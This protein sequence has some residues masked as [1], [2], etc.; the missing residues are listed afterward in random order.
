MAVINQNLTTL[1]GGIGGLITGFRG[2]SLMTQGAEL[3]AAGF[4][5]AGN[6]AMAAAQYNTKL[7]DVNLQRQLSDMAR[8]ISLVSGAQTAAA[9]ASGFSVTSK[10]TLQVMDESLASFEREI[11]RLQNNA[12]NEKQGILFEG[13][14]AKAANEVQ[15][16]Q[17]EFSAR[18]QR[19]Q[20][21]QGLIGSGVKLLGSLV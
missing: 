17:A 18:Q 8:Q 13:R 9:S 12:Q 11:L 5:A 2:I 10:S 3:Q 21:V 1:L 16:R 19:S 4:R 6:N 14:S 15:A 7:V 20:A